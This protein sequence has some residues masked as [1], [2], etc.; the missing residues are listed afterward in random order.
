MADITSNSIVPEMER[1]FELPSPRLHPGIYVSDF[2]VLRSIEKPRSNI[3]RHVALRRGLNIIWADPNPPEKPITG[4]RSKVAGHTAGKS[5]FCRLL[6]Y[7]LGDVSYGNDAQENKII[8]KFMNGW[9]VLRVELEGDPWI[10]GRSFNDKNS[11]FAIPSGDLPTFLAGYLQPA[12]GYADFTAALDSLFIKP[13]I[14]QKFPG[15][16]GEIHWRHLIPWFTRDQ[17]ARLLSLTTWR[18][19]VGKTN[20]LNTDSDERHFLMRLILGLLP[21]GEVGEFDRHEE[22]N[23]RKRELDK[24]LPLTR[25]KTAQA[26]SQL[27]EWIDVETKGLEEPLFHAAAKAAHEAKEK[28]LHALHAELPSEF[29]L[30]AA[31][32]SWRLAGN[33]VAQAAAELRAAQHRVKGLQQAIRDCD[34]HQIEQAAAL[35]DINRQPSA[36]ACGIPITEACEAGKRRHADLPASDA[37]AA[38]LQVIAKSKDKLV[39]DQ[40][41]AEEAVV[42]ARA[43]VSDAEKAELKSQTAYLTIASKRANGLESY[44][45]AKAE[46]AAR[47]RVLE[48]SRKVLE[49]KTA[50]E[51]LLESTAKYIGK[52]TEQEARERKESDRDRGHFSALY[53]R[54]L[55]YM[56]GEEVTGTVD[57]N[58]RSLALTAEGRNDLDSGAIT[59][60]KLISFDL[61]AMAW[62]MENRGHHPRFVIHDSPRE[63]D[64]A[65]DIYAGLFEAA[66][67]MER[68]FVGTEPSFQYIVTTTATPPDEWNR[69]PWRREPVLNALVK[70]KRILGEDL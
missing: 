30:Q 34:A 19:P 21:K 13:L 56:L 26:F 8:N 36:L 6:R 16:R 4:K 46:N 24:T 28:K 32:D 60:A 64:M 63:A 66:I 25:A 47:K 59:A 10:V 22:L 15:K 57:Q 70:D 7:A 11:S 51:A 58:G 69:L 5:T 45:E 52:S 23:E 42:T 12:G 37:Y 3:Q 62:A 68:C 18:A 14:T 54:V 48:S 31:Q 29:E 53:Q 43:A 39:S 35:E 33:K 38:V 67:E 50:E 9:V 40:A 2:Y 41:V 17:E 20:A 1:R 27:S 55:R 61:A 65:E 44:F 49:Q